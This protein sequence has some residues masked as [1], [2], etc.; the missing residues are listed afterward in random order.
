M[1]SDN[2]KEFEEMSQRIDALSNLISSF[3]KKAS[4]GVPQDIQDRVDAITQ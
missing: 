3:G 4:G 2:R 1:A